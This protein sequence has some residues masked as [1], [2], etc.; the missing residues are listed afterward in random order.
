MSQAPSKRSATI[1]LG[2]IALLWLLVFAAGVVLSPSQQLPFDLGA[3]V[4]LRLGALRVPIESPRDLARLLTCWLV[5]IN[6][7]H[8]LGNLAVLVVI[9]WRWPHRQSVLFPPIVGVLLTG[10]ASLWLS[11]SRSMVS[12]GGS[13]VLLALLGSLLRQSETWQARV[14]PV[15]LAT[16]LLGGGLWSSGDWAAHVGG[17]LAGGVAALLVQRRKTTG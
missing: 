12:C 3:P 16:L 1:I 8:L 14:T 10:V 9:A 2:M 11:S 17:L 7:W 6:L 13:G 15:L 5:H 4:L